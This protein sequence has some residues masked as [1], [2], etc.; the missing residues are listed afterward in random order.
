MMTESNF[1][2]FLIFLTEII[3]LNPSNQP[4]ILDIKFIIIIEWWL[5]YSNSSIHVE[6]LKT[7]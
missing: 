1:G 6:Q 5:F 4:L 7:L 3:I 2:H